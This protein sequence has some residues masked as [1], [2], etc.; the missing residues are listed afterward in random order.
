MREKCVNS[1]IA[2]A[3]A[4]G[5]GVAAVATT[6]APASAA[7]DSAAAAI[8]AAATDGRV[9][10]SEVVA[11]ARFWYEER[12]D[13]TYDNSRNSSSFY[14][15][16]GGTRYAPD[17]SGYISMAWHLDNSDGGLNTS[18]LPDV[19]T[20]LASAPSSS[21]DLR[22]GDILDD[23]G[24]H[25]VLFDRWDTD[26][27]H[28]W[29]YSFGSSPITH[30]YTSFDAPLLSSHPTS[31]YHAYRYYKIT[32][33]NRPAGP[34]RVNSGGSSTVQKRWSSSDKLSPTFA[35]ATYPRAMWPR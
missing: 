25:V 19:S 17:C 5:L 30:G 11:R 4:A 33:G 15:D 24:K 21:T 3:V 32:E 27:V 35:T 14:A 10:R 34:L 20:M 18:T 29:Y 26:H 28:F 7:P 31:E 2:L 8:A 12:R 9:T 1:A 22:P 13:L 6:A 16:S 23:P